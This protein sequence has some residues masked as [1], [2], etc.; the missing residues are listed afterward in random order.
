MEERPDLLYS[1]RMA[2]LIEKLRHD[3]DVVLIDTP[4]LL[5]LPDARIIGRLSDGVILVLRAGRARWES[6]LAV[7]RR[8]SEDGIPIVG[9]V[10]NGWHPQRD[11]Y[12]VYPRDKSIYSYIAG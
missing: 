6:A 8:L 12:G 4:P 11:G 3:Y 1:S 2:E 5:H 9:T 10:L 7:E